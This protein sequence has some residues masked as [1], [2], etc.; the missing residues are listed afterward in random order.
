MNNNHNQ[1]VCLPLQI[2]EPPQNLAMVGQGVQGAKWL[3]VVVSLLFTFPALE[4]HFTCLLDVPWSPQRLASMCFACDSTFE[5]FMQF[6]L[7][8]NLGITSL[9]SFRRR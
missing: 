7:H 6:T 5:S 3:T 8:I 1:M 4:E 9:E 2:K